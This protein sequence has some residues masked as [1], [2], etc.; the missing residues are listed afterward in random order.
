MP[1][2]FDAEGIKLG[3]DFV[4]IPEGQY[5]F[6]VEDID[7]GFTKDGNQRVAIKAKIL[8]GEF[9]GETLPHTV[10]FLPKGKKG[11]GFCLVFLKAIGEPYEGKIQVTPIDW[12]GKKFVGHVIVDKW[13]SDQKQK[14]MESNKIVPWEI[15]AYGAQEIPLQ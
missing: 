8:E 9:M 5:A 7:E 15:S 13:F 1:F 14:W 10:S 12:V 11:A 6:E 4:L 3:G 2:E